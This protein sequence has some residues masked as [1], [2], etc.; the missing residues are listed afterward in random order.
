[1]NIG[2]PTSLEP[3]P[4]K[5]AYQGFE[6]P[7]LGLPGNRTKKSPKG[8]TGEEIVPMDEGGDVCESRVQTPFKS[9]GRL[10]SDWAACSLGGD[11]K[12]RDT[13]QPKRS[14]DGNQEDNR[15]YLV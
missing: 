13:E 15:N 9:R 3:A 7:Q 12:K 11:Q 4:G 2:L 14:L 6:E 1:L 10:N 5:E 8:H